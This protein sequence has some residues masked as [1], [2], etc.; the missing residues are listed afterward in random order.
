MREDGSCQSCSFLQSVVFIMVWKKL[1]NVGD[2]CFAVLYIYVLIWPSE[3]LQ[4][5]PGEGSRS[6]IG[7]SIWSRS[8]LSVCITRICN[9]VTLSY[10][11]H[12]L[13]SVFSHFLIHFVSLCN[14]T[15]IALCNLLF[16]IHQT[17]VLCDPF[18]HTLQFNLYPYIGVKY[19]F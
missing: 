2:N 19:N 4:G 1:T 5:F 16:E 7:D 12:A 14:P 11:C 3:A 10:P 15:R 8:P 6:F 9:S 13:Q 18:F 17:F